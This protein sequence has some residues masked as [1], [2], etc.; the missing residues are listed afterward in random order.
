MFDSSF[1]Q[2]YH[3]PIID[4]DRGCVFGTESII[5]STKDFKQH[6]QI[7]SNLFDNH[8]IDSVNLFRWIL[9][10]ALKHSIFMKNENINIINFINVSTENLI[11]PY[12]F[13]LLIEIFEHPDSK[14]L[15]VEFNNKK[16]IIDNITLND[17]IY[18][19]KKLGI[20]TSID[21]YGYNLELFTD[22][23]YPSNNIKIDKIFIKNI[24]HS[25]YYR[26]LLK[27]MIDLIHMADK[28]PIVSG[29]DTLNKA[30]IVHDLG[31]S[32]IQGNAICQPMQYNQISNW[33]HMSNINNE[34][35]TFPI[36]CLKNN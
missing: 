7:D 6:N 11:N 30:F 3:Q 33:I 9:L 17:L 36:S 13:N 1:F 27:S 35:W 23:L 19:I 16:S 24:E 20:I 12:F 22:V 28:K 18:N 15:G 10:E 31:C 34:W 5:R 2:L 4:L 25:E 32:L 14:N 21:S 8:E 29:V 26:D